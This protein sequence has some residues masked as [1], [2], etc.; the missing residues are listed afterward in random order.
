MHALSWVES[1]TIMAYVTACHV[2]F[3]FTMFLCILCALR[4]CPHD[5]PFGPWH[6]AWELD[7][8]VSPQ[9][10][11]GLSSQVLVGCNNKH[12]GYRT[13]IDRVYHKILVGRYHKHWRATSYNPAG[14]LA[15]Q[16]NI[17]AS[18]THYSPCT[19]T[20][21][22]AHVHIYHYLA[23]VHKYIYHYLAHK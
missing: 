18:L 9:H 10:R 8:R 20:I 1:C 17:F 13:S 4:S 19:R 2:E 22:L 6:M 23:H 15:G 16:P 21:V 7:F 12:I 11:A 5:M 14:Q 3:S